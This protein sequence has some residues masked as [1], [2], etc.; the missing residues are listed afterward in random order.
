MQGPGSLDKAYA[1]GRAM[2]STVMTNP[3][4]VCSEQELRPGERTPGAF[5]PCPVLWVAIQESL[6]SWAKWFIWGLT[7]ISPILP[8]RKQ[9]LSKDKR[10]SAMEA[11]RS[12]GLKGELLT[13]L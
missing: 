3:G 12:I 7:G 9:K 10:A 5:S 6:T 11:G 13:V 2:A 1:C 4:S 8:L